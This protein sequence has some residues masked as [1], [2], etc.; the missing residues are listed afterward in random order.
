MRN[1]VTFVAS[2]RPKWASRPFCPAQAFSQLISRICQ[3]LWPLMVALHPDLGAD[4]RPVRGPAIQLD[5]QPMVGVAVVSVEQVL[6]GHCVTHG[7]EEIEEAIVVVVSPGSGTPPAVVINRTAG[8][9]RVNVP[10]RLLWNRHERVGRTSMIRLCRTCP[11]SHRC[12]SRPTPRRYTTEALLALRAAIHWRTCRHPSCER[13]LSKGIS[14][15]RIQPAVVIVICPPSR[16]PESAGIPK[17]VVLT[18][19]PSA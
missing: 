13:E 18:K 15:E 6:F 5:L 4:G 17:G 11:A 16:A 3:K 9:N 2:P 7:D 14:T 10:S 19:V 1:V 12:R 8:E